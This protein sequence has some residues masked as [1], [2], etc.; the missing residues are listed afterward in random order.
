M[1]SIRFLKAALV[2]AIM[3]TIALPIR[4]DRDSFTWSMVKLAAGLFFA[5]W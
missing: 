5:D 1:R 3:A 2:L 4:F